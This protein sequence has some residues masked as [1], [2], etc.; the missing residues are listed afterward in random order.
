MKNKLREALL[1]RKLSLGAW[2]QIG[3]TAVA[4]ILACAGFDWV[5]VDLE[6]GAI[7]LETMAGIFRT[8]DAYECVPVARVPKNDPI[9][10]RRS[11]DAGARGLIIPMVNTAEEA[12]AAI[13]EAKYPPRGLRG[14]GYSRANMHGAE[15]DAYIAEA[16]D[17]IAMIMQIEHKDAIDNLDVI[18]EVDGVDGLFV[19]PLD[20]SASMGITGHLDHPDMTGALQEYRDACDAHKVA[21][22][23]HIVE[24][25]DESIRKATDEG[26]NLLALGLDNVFIRQAATDALQAARQELG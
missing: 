12:G 22:G 2:M 25:D 6:H 1:S 9:W 18:L 13:R 20:L 24:P 14:F 5:C 10:I 11:L 8:L 17:E 15:F 4:E 7:G 21:A 19:G 3:H 16:N 26:Y 23:M